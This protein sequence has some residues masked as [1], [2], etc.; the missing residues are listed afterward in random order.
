MLPHSYTKTAHFSHH[1][2]Y[3]SVIHVVVLP[4]PH[5]ALKV[6]AAAAAFSVMHEVEGNSRLAGLAPVL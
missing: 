3:F 2:V 4:I 6:L 5:C 1:N